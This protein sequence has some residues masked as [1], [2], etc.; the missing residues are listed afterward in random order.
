MID[1]HGTWK[2]FGAGDGLQEKSRPRE[3][4]ADGGSFFFFLVHLAVDAE[5]G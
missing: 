4:G 5:T 3:P 2:V 1:S